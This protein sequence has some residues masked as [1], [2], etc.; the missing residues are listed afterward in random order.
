MGFERITDLDPG[1]V[2]CGFNRPAII[3]DLLRVR[4]KIGALIDTLGEHHVI[5]LFRR[6]LG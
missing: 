6:S 2:I 4:H 5:G 3:G 1:V